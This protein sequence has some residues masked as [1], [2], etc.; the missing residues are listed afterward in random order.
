MAR[1][2]GAY[3]P[4]VPEGV[5]AAWCVHNGGGDQRPGLRAKGTIAAAST[6]PTGHK[7]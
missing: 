6:V 1:E 5:R 4:A 2:L 3:G 7:C